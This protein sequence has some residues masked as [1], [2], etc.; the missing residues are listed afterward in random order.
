MQEQGMGVMAAVATSV[1]GSAASAVWN[2]PW[3]M[4]SIKTYVASYVAWNYGPTI[5]FHS[6]IYL[7]R[8]VIV[9]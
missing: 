9:G 5:L 6:G 7:G 4:A 2:S 3:A 1:A 8:R